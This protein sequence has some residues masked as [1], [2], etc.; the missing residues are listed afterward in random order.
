[1]AGRPI[2]LRHERFPRIADP[3]PTLEVLRPIHE[4]L[5]VVLTAIDKVRVIQRQLDGAVDE[6]VGGLDAEHEA[7]V[8]VADFVAP[9][10]EAAAGEDVLFLEFGEE[11]FEDALA[12]EGWGGIAVVEAAVV[13]GYDFVGGF[14]HL[15]G[16]EAL[17][18][19]F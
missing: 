12:F 18:G 7:V 9:A 17:D 4:S 5:L 8:L 13:G 2:R 1:M 15:G 16:D 19:V 3:L 11:L 6:R 14:E 10:A